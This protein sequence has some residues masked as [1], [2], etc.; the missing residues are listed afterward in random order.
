MLKMENKFIID[1]VQSLVALNDLEV[2][3]EEMDEEILKLRLVSSKWPEKG[4]RLRYFFV[5]NKLKN[6]E[7]YKDRLVIIK[8]LDN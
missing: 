8:C 6:E 2:E 4:L 7:W 1:R 3:I 5:D